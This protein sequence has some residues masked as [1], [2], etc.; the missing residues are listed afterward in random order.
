LKKDPKRVIA[1][2]ELLA[3]LVA[4][5]LWIRGKEH[6]KATCYLK[7]VTDN[8]GNTFGSFETTIS[9]LMT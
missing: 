7:G 1:T 5:K 8:L 3:S 9:L 6:I 2:L 4:A